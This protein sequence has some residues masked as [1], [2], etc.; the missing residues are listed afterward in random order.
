MQAISILRI[1]RSVSIGALLFSVVGALFLTLR[2]S[3]P[4]PPLEIEF[5]S[6][7]GPGVVLLEASD[8]AGPDPFTTSVAV[9]LDL[10]PALRVRPAANATVF[11][12]P[13]RRSSPADRLVADG[14]GWELAGRPERD[15]TIAVDRVERLA[16]QYLGA[17][18]RLT[19]LEDRNGDG[20]DDDGRF[21]VLAGD[22]S[23]VCVE[24]GPARILPAA[25]GAA[26]DPE[27]R[28]AVGGVRW[29][30]TGPCA[31]G[32]PESL[33]RQVVVGSTPGLY[34]GL[35]AG[36]VCDAAALAERLAA[37]PAV[38]EAWG[39]VHGIP[40]ESLGE[41][42]ATLTPV[43]LLR[44]TLVTNYGW[45]SG[46][47]IPRQ[48]VLET[49]TAVLVDLRG[50]P[51]ARCASGSPLQPPAGLPADPAF[52]GTGWIGFDRDLVDEVPPADR[53]QSVFLLLELSDGGVLRRTPG[54]VG[55]SGSLAGP[56]ADAE[57]PPIQ[58]PSASS[59]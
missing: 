47:I 18:D 26:V 9:E 4:E 2:V 17:D 3:R 49:G 43:V 58:T 37:V 31:G 19:G 35:R 46:R 51:A 44:D 28:V 21:T 20:R 40:P 15:R 7:Y 25:L 12:S 14:F 55:A 50:V 10:D 39:L 8:T 22:G 27:D 34:G 38:G 57:P 32:D 16:A 13:H 11:L 36:E 48:S 30:P 56:V 53:D 42:I 59:S 24:A 5:G 41:F 29:D 54:F 1:V 52:Q 6:G 33:G 45:R 23:A